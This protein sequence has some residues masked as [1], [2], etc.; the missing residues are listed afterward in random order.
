MDRGELEVLDEED[1]KAILDELLDEPEMPESGAAGGTSANLRDRAVSA[2]KAPE[3]ARSAGI[4]SEPAVS[5]SQGPENT[6]IQPS[7]DLS[8]TVEEL[9][10]QIESR[11]QEHIRVMVESKLPDLVRSIIDEELQKLRKELQ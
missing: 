9:I 8:K 4:E 5:G 2:M 1:E 10:D 6:P 7:A 3:E 11:L